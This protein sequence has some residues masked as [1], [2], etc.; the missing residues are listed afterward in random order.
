MGSRCLLGTAHPVPALGVGGGASIF[1]LGVA[2]GWWRSGT[3]MP[4]AL[5]G[6]GNG[7]VDLGQ[8]GRWRTL[9]AA[10]RRRGGGGDELGRRPGRW[11][12]QAVG[13]W[14]GAAQRCG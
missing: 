7:G 1:L 6:G 2:A 4:A 13:W 3:P 10:A 11:R 9:A 8:Q 14:G 5:G 12:T